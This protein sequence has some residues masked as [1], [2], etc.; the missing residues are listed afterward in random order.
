MK[1]ILELV[2]KQQKLLDKKLKTIGEN[3]QVVCITHQ[4]VLQL[5]V[6][7]RKLF[8]ES[9]ITNEN[10]THTVIKHLN[11]NE[12]IDEIAKFQM[13]MLLILLENMQKN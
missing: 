3:H 9:K 12:V 2:E 5:K 4:Q 13:V 10:R 8:Y 6:M 11:E 1:S 7:K